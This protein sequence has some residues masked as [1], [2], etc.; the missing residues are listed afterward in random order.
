MV[1]QTPAVTCP[2]ATRDRTGPNSASRRALSSSSSH[3]PIPVAWGAQAELIYLSCSPTLGSSRVK[4][5]TR[6]DLSINL[7]SRHHR[8]ARARQEIGAGEPALGDTR[9]DDWR[10]CHGLSRNADNVIGATS[11]ILAVGPYP[12]LE[13]EVLL[14]YVCLTHNGY[15]YGHSAA[16]EL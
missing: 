11:S 4:V 8:L 6:E 3:K 10:S 12:S 14:S 1:K 5:P 2:V 15:W 16:V 13:S 7:S 9:P